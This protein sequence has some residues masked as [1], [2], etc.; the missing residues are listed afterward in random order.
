MSKFN[1]AWWGFIVAVVSAIAA[2]I[3]IPQIGCKVG[4]N[5]QA[6]ISPLKEA[7]LP[8]QSLETRLHKTWGLS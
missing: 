5:P 7:T 4:L 6:C 8:R 3:N 2:I 1:L